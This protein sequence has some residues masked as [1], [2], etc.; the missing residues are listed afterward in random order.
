MHPYQCIRIKLPSVNIFPSK[1]KKRKIDASSQGE[2][3]NRVFTE[4][5]EKL[6]T[7]ECKHEQEY[8]V[9]QLDHPNAILLHRERK[10]IT[11]FLERE[12]ES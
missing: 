5:Y 4:A 1:P 10:P 8:W 11:T 12:R 9:D 3:G 7:E 2:A 6:V